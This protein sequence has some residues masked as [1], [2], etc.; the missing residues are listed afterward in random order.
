MIIIGTRNRVSIYILTSCKVSH[1][2]ALSSPKGEDAVL[3]HEV[4]LDIHS[5]VFLW[6]I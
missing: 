6:L 1:S 5:H 4:V 3:Y 2:F